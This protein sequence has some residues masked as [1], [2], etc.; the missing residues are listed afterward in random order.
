L[1]ILSIFNQKSSYSVDEIRSLTEIETENDY[2]YKIIA[3][4]LKTK[5]LTSS[6][7]GSELPSGSDQISVNEAYKRYCSELNSSIESTCVNGIFSKKKKMNISQPIKQETKTESDLT[8]KRVE[9]D[10]GLATQVN[11]GV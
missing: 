9:E 8:V 5:V 7:T 3:Q 4:L 11:F 6:A 10:R 2:L 1:S